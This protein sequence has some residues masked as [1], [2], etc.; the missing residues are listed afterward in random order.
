MGGEWS[1]R[2]ITDAGCHSNQ[3]R[4]YME[5]GIITGES[6]PGIQ[7]LRPIPVHRND[8]VTVIVA[9][10]PLLPDDW[11]EPARWRGYATITSHT[12]R[13]GYPGCNRGRSI[14]T[15][16]IRQVH[17]WCIGRTGNRY[18]QSKRTE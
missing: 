1:D 12:N 7:Q 5:S 6:E 2:A 17:W 9:D 16:T 8:Y 14:G 15:T 10:L 3:G 4:E 13:T 18:P 11:K